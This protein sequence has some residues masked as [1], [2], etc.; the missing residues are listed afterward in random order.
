M[1]LEIKLQGTVFVADYKNAIFE[2][3]LQPRSVNSIKN[4]QF[5]IAIDKKFQA[6]KPQRGG[7]AHEG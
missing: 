3:F 4:F 7:H 2:K 6:P 5:L 1:G